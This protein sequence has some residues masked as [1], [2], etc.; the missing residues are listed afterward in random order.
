MISGAAVS[1]QIIDIPV[2]KD[3]YNSNKQDITGQHFKFY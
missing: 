3:N 2:G 1:S